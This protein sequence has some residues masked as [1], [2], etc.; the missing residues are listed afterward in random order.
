MTQEERMNYVEFR[1]DLLREGT[2][3]TKYIYDCEVTEEQLKAL[4]DIMDGLRHEIDNGNEVSSA[5]YETEVLQIVDSRKLDYHFCESFARLLWEERRYEEVFPAL[6]GE[7]MKF[8]H[9]F[10]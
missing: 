4:Y 9:L 8:K 2:D 10:E 7:S 5:A 1:M 3:F 6:Y